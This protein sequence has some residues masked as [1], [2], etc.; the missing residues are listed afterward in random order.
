MYLSLHFLKNPVTLSVETAM[1][2]TIVRMVT[3]VTHHSKGRGEYTGRG[4][5]CDIRL[6]IYYRRKSLHTLSTMLYSREEFLQNHKMQT[7]TK[8]KT[9]QNNNNKNWDWEKMR[10]GYRNWDV[11]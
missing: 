3:E 1:F 9:K 6:L 8:T 10:E 5:N 4:V 2:S 7:K 11:K